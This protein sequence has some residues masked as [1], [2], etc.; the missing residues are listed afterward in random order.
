MSTRQDLACRIAQFICHNELTRPYGGDVTKSINHYSIAF[1][2]CG[3][4]GGVLDGVVKV[5]GPK[6]IQIMYLTQ[7]RDLPHKD[8]RVFTSEADAID[9]LNNAFVRRDFEAALA[10][11]TKVTA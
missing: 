7:Y 1:A 11:P 6:F 10:I 4:A 8:S 2:D 5:Y 9:F 3:P